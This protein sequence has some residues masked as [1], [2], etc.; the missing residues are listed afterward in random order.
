MREPSPFGSGLG[1][2]FHRVLRGWR[3]GGRQGGPHH[4]ARSSHHS[5]TSAPAG[6]ESSV[7]GM[8]A[9]ASAAARAGDH[10]APLPACQPDVDAATFVAHRAAGR[11]AFG[12]DAEERPA[13]VALRDGLVEDGAVD[14]RRRSC[15]PARARIAGRTNSSKVTADDTGL[16]GSPNTS[17]GLHHPGGRRPRKRRAC[18]AG[19][20]RARGLYPPDRFHGRLDDVVRADRDTARDDQRVHPGVEPPPQTAG[21]RRRDRRRRCRDRSPRRQRP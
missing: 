6:R 21:G 16:P 15:R 9:K 7:S 20:R 1:S 13:P 4:H 2:R 5:A 11:I 8:T 12:L 18:R 3:S 19:W 17:T 10:V 14:R